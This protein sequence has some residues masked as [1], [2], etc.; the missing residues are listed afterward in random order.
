MKTSS[1][2]MLTAIL[3][4]TLVMAACSG[5][6]T[7]TTT[8]SQPP[9]TTPATSQTTTTT[10]T[11]KPPTTTTTPPSTGMLPVTTAGTKAP[12][13]GVT[14]IFSDLNPGPSSTPTPMPHP[15]VGF[16]NCLTCHYT[17]MAVG[18]QFAVN[19]DHPCN[20]CHAVAPKYGF[21]PAHYMGVPPILP[22]QDSCILC[23]Q[24]AS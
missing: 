18:S 4:T 9:T 19:V 24:P 3:V 8:S 2:F 17:E 10:T 22:M 16:E 13:P 5:G 15:I 14:V 6:G 11:S 12:P 21:D 1:Y 7:Q 23:H 20:E